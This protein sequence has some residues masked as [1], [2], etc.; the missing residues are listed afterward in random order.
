M[1][2]I[3]YASLCSGYGGLDLAVERLWP[4]TSMAWHAQYDPTDRK[5]YAAKIMAHHWPDAPNHGDI[6]NIN[7]HEVPRVNILTAGF[8]CQ[9]ISLAGHG[10]GIKEGTRSG[11]WANVAEAVGVLRPGLVILENSSAI[12]T[13]GGRRVVGDL[14]RLGYDARWTTLRASDVGAPH[15]RHRWYCVASPAGDTES[16][17]RYAWQIGQPEER[18]QVG[19][20]VRDS[21]CRSAGPAEGLMG[22]WGPYEGAIRRWEWLTRAVPCGLVESSKSA[23]GFR[24]NPEFYEWMMGLPLGWVTGV[25]GLPYGAQVR[26][27]GNGN[28]VQQAD[29]AL[30][31]LMHRRNA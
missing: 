4:N 19:D 17:E 23:S 21:G 30:R 24:A 3:T 20:P 6:T 14:A 5:Q 22:E 25:P 9:D 8:P 11:I 31:Y 28:V 1:P 18:N 27:L 7:W 10:A 29:A 2:H 15:P 16:F 12:L 26:A 13:R